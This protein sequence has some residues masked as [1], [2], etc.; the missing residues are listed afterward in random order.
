MISSK[1]PHLRQ[2]SRCW[3]CS[4]TTSGYREVEA[5]APPLLAKF[6]MDMR[7]AMK[8]KDRTRLNVIRGVLTETTTLDKESRA[9]KSNKQ[10]FK[11]L[12]KRINASKRAANEFQAAGREDLTSKEN[13]QIG[14]LQE[15]LDT[16][17]VPT[18]DE[19]VATIQDLVHSLASEGAP[20]RKATVRAELFSRDDSPFRDKIVDDRLVTET[21][22]RLVNKTAPTT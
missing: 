20:P 7:E 5:R 12:E 11:L 10:L 19:T 1:T 6:R 16:F 18:A 4:F 2:F 17:D 3:R 22:E 13:E 21:I 15:Y 14:I 9:I 8:A